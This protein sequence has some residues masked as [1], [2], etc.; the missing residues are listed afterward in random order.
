MHWWAGGIVAVV[1]LPLLLFSC[2]SGGDA[3]PV[4]SAPC[5][6]TVPATLAADEALDAASEQAAYIIQ[7]GEIQ[8]S[9]AR[10][11]R[12]GQALGEMRAHPNFSGWDADACVWL[13]ILDGF[14]YAPGPD[15]SR[16]PTCGRIGV[17]IRPDTGAYLHITWESMTAD[18]A[19]AATAFKK[20]V[21]SR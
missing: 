5:E 9:S 7:D 13:V 14:F 19:D 20:T 8:R 2:T 6:S 12:F 11:M 1:G 10:F 21:T 3:G 17:A 16:G 18:E 15:G 4:A